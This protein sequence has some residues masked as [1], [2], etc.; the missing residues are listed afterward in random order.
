MIIELWMNVIAYKIV[1][2]KLCLNATYEY[3]L[4]T[5]MYAMTSCDLR[6]AEA[7]KTL[8]ILSCF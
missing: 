4:K 1:F 5:S 3:A 8:G 6:E 7:A 2:A